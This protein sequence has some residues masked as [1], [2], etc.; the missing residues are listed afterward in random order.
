MFVSIGA[1][2][3]M[4]KKPRGTLAGYTDKALYVALAIRGR[5]KTMLGSDTSPPPSIV[6]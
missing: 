2:M 6:K 4:H 1:G 3:S 5:N